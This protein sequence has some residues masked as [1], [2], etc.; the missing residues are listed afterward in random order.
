MAT[1]IATRKT[2]S[3]IQGL[4]YIRAADTLY[5]VSANATAAANSAGINRAI[6][7]AVAAKKIVQLPSGILQIDAPIVYDPRATV[8]GQGRQN[9]VIKAVSQIPYAVGYLGDTLYEPEGIGLTEFAIDCN[10]LATDGLRIESSAFFRHGDIYI[11]NGPAGGA[12]VRIKGSLIGEFNTVQ[13]EL[14]DGDG[15]VIGERGNVIVGGT[16]LNAGT[17]TMPPNLLMFNALYIL[18]CK[19]R[20][21]TYTSG[22]GLHINFLDCEQNGASLP[23]NSGVIYAGDTCT[24]AESQGLVINRAWCEVNY[25]DF[26]FE[27]QQ[28]RYATAHSISNLQYVQGSGRCST[29]IYA[30]GGSS[31]LSVTLDSVHS[32]GPTQFIYAAGA[33]T[34]AWYHPNCRNQGGTITGEVGTKV[35]KMATTS[36]VPAGGGGASGSPGSVSDPALPA[37]A[38]PRFY[39]F[40]E[41]CAISLPHVPGMQTLVFFLKRKALSGETT[42]PNERILYDNRNVNPAGGTTGSGYVYSNGTASVDDFLVNGVSQMN[43]VPEETLTAAFEGTWKTLIIQASNMDMPTLLARCTIAE[44]NVTKASIGAIHVYN[45]VLSVSEKASLTTNAPATGLV[46]NWEPLSTKFIFNRDADYQWVDSIGSLEAHVQGTVQL[47]SY[48]S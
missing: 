2:T 11:K 21:I 35:L 29:L 43:M 45:R 37:E 5:G 32:N 1:L 41:A 31:E 15:V 14:C 16:G 34:T 22:A 26:L 8:R 48:S 13:V 27:L 42:P 33:K 40:Q 20:A 38:H 39:M 18:A 3:A 28:G 25:A 24:A 46:A 23:A 17:V 10:K 19:K 6:V 4:D 9:T 36:D 7:D 12:G 30:N 44:S 47:Y